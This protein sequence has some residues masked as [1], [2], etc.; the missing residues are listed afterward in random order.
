MRKATVT[1]VLSPSIT[2]V[3]THTHT[4]TQLTHTTP[5]ARPEQP[6]NVR[7][8]NT[9]SHSITLVWEEPH[10]NNTPIAG[11]RVTYKRPAF[12]G[13]SDGVQVVNSTVEMAD[14]TGLHPS[15]TYNFTVVAFNEIGDSAPSDIVSVSTQQLDPDSTDRS[16]LTI[17]IAGV[18]AGVSI[19]AT[20]I[21]LV[22]IVAVVRRRRTSHKLK[23]LNKR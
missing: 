11:Y 9:T 14:I 8:V 7:S 17:I 18:A 20:L 3:D 13:I 16:S 22:V 5:T 10:N 21:T 15:V 6:Q 4:H 23:D 12:N 2:L 19:I 1:G